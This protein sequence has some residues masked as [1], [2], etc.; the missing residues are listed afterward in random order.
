MERT[1]MS[2]IST[3]SNQSVQNGI[4]S[5]LPEEFYPACWQ[6]DDRMDNLFAP[7]REKTVNPVNYETKMKFWKNLIKEYCTTK[8]SATISL[9]ELRVVFERKG[10]RPHCLNTVLDELLSEGMAKSKSQFMESPLT[11]T[12][13]AIE[14]LVKSPFRWGFDKVKERVISSANNGNCD[15]NYEFV[16]IEV[17][18]VCYTTKTVL[19]NNVY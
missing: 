10:K 8:G 3:G 4:N 19:V 7:F 11:W 5:N 1:E 15:E 12:G 6:D 17:A 14:K 13:W 2:R 18:K 16:M 9:S